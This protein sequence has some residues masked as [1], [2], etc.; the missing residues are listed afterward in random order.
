MKL[1]FGLIL[2]CLF[3]AGCIERTELGSKKNPIHISLTPGKDIAALTTSGNELKD[4]LEKTLDLHFELH[5][6]PSYVAVVESFGT[7]RTDFAILNTMGYLIS[8]EK[9]GAE[10]IFTLT[11]QGREQYRGQI[12][13]RQNGPKNLQELNGKKFAYVDPISASGH[14]L[15]AHLF[16]KNNI[17][18]KEFVFA[19]R[20]DAVV[21]MVYQG[22][23][24]A[25]A[26]FWSPE[27]NGEPFDAR[28][29]VTTQ[30]P[31]VYKKIKI[32]AYTDYL[33]NEAF[34]VRKDFP[35]DM[36]QKV[37]RALVSWSATD[38]GKKTLKDLYNNDGLKPATD[39]DYEP[40][41]KLLKDLNKQVTDLSL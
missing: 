35:D 21:S 1:K 8:H 34:V 15:P 32:I 2:C 36:K 12:I 39:A 40:A 37:I 28:K 33:P 26:T 6:P 9:Y 19:G 17:K 4:H 31:D 25:G 23:V 14:L 30:Y 18:L 38:E 24:D 41:R 7:K 22:Q 5:V 16:Q 20:H 29:L 27:E 13:A 11:N 3:F 10:A